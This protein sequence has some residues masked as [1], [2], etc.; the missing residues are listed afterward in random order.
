[1]NRD[2]DTARDS[3]WRYDADKAQAYAQRSSKRSRQEA[4]L[5]RRALAGI[6]L[7]VTLDAPCGGGRLA[8]LLEE[9]QATWIGL[10]ASSAMLARVEGQRLRV[11]ARLER[12]PIADRGVDSVVCFRYL[13]HVEPSEQRRAVKE[14][15]RCAA[16][17]FVASAFHPWSTHRLTRSFR[18]RRS[19]RAVRFCLAPSQLD[20]WLSEQGFEPVRKLR[21]GL[22]RDLWIGVWRREGSVQS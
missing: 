9:L 21:Q 5:L 15:A 7:G 11:R 8:P 2:L 3:S 22:L 17:I 18:A 4:E 6:E 1:M 12:L 20:A 14:L 13:H 19:G 10:D 16:S